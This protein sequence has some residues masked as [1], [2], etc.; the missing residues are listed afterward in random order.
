MLEITDDQAAAEFARALLTEYLTPAFGTRPKTE[1][2]QLIFDLLIRTNVIPPTTHPFDIARHLNIP[3]ARAKRLLM[4][5]QMRSGKIDQKLRA[6]LIERLSHVRFVPDGSYVNVGIV[7]ALLREYFIAE[8]QRRDVFPDSGTAREIVRVPLGGFVDMLVA[9]APEEVT[10][11]VA[12]QVH[13]QLVKGGALPDTS[14][15]GIFKEILVKA[16][17]QI[18]EKAVGDLAG[19]AAGSM[20]DFVQGLFTGNTDRAATAAA[21]LVSV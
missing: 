17:G 18:G 12:R 10:K 21:A 14:V 9:I 19:R 15:K 20:V 6:D 4:V 11:D 8:L 7:D 16:A 5:W 3:V 2:D 1:I 13:D